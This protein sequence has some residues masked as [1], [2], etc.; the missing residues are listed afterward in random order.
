MTIPSR[1]PP[2]AALRAFAMVGRTGGIR[3]AADALAISHAIVSRHLAALEEALGV[4]LLNRQTGVLTEAGQA[5]H[6]R[7]SAAIGEMEAATEALRGR[8]GEGL[9]IWC[10]AGF[11]LLWLA[12]RLPEFA[13]A[14]G[15]LGRPVIDLRST[16]TEPVFE[17]HEADGDIRY[18]FDGDPAGIPRGVRAEEL[19]RPEVFPVAAPELLARVGAVRVLADLVALPLIQESSAAE[20]AGWLTAQHGAAQ[21]GAAQ[22]GAPVARYGQAHLTLAAARAG[23]G[24]ALSNRFLVAEDLASGRLVRVAP[25]DEPLVAVALG[26]YYFRCARAR[27]SDPLLARFRAWLARAI[28][29][30]HS[31]L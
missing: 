17:R 14:A 23:Q 20:W 8:R 19:A 9:T 2:F 18:R 6:A 30:D 16:E 4:M 31:S 11:S 15:A 21:H 1:L 22:L 29:A 26:A 24:V 7:I 12:R 10:S 3:K 5:Y 13:S 25:S 28:A 27:W